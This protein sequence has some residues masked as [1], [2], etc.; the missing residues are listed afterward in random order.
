MGI[1]LGNL[2]CEENS[3]KVICQ[4]IVV[5]LLTKLEMWAELNL[6]FFSPPKV[7]LVF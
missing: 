2:H 1:Q 3:F 7:F 5:R 4:I 6:F